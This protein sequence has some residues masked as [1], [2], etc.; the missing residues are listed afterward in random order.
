[1]VPLCLSLMMNSFKNEI[2]TYKKYI[3]K[4]L[5][6]IFIF[7]FL[8]ICFFIFDIMTGPAELSF[9]SVIKAILSKIYNFDIAKSSVNIVYNI[10]L[11]MALMALV[12]GSAL[13]LSGALMQTILNNHLASPYTLGLSTAAGFGASIVIAFNIHLSFINVPLGAFIMCFLSSSILF[14]F[15][16]KYQTGTLVLVG[17]AIL[18]LFQSLLSLVQFLVSPE[19]SQNI[20]FW[21]FGS[22]SKANYTNI[23]IVFSAT[24]FA[25]LWLLK[26]N[27]ALSVF[28]M[29]EKNARVLGVNI[30]RLRIKVL[31][32]VCLVSSLA[33]AFV[34]VIGFIG[35]AAPHIAR[36]LVGEDQRFL[37]PASM[38]IG[39][40]LL[41]IA[42]SA[43]KIIIPG[44]LFPIGIVTSFIGVPFFFYIILRK[45][46]A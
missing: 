38:A 24:I 34:G 37:Y 17:I 35:L 3:Q 25:Y 22:L 30:K 46:N 11:P 43:S 4:R 14:A 41:S 44:A 1:M 32:C 12:V 5:I 26:D 21:L 20:L 23:A 15:A 27:W 19:T 45:G 2:K 6:F 13:G 29:G 42:S 18:F 28:K 9:L 39:A 8:A 10:R 40:L 7:I 36:I 16:K 33:V 31:F